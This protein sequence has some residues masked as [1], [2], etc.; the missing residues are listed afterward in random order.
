MFGSYT[1]KQIYI[2]YKR[3]PILKEN[4]VLSDAYVRLER[5]KEREVPIEEP[6]G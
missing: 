1:W 5:E 2:A 6:P 3:M 4:N